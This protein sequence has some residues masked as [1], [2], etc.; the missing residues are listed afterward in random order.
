MAPKQIRNGVA[1]TT[2]LLVL[3]AVTGNVVRISF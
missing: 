3:L 1:V 2:S